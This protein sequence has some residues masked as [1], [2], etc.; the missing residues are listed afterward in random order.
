V[1]NS[2]DKGGLGNNVDPDKPYK[3]GN[4]KPPLETQFQ[5]GVSGNPGGR[6]KGRSKDLVNF[7]DILMK[8]FYKTVPA[9]LAGKV[10]NKTQGEILAMQMMKAAIS[11]TMS[12][13]RLLLQ[14]IEAHE[15]R[16]A[17]REEIKLKKQ[18]E[19]SDEIDW[20]AE[21]EEVYQ[22]LRKATA[23]I[24]QSTAPKKDE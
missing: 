24:V 20:D 23:E 14:F 22:Q 15:A 18:A 6:P 1:S 7:G 12:D 3:V 10:V 5:K 13:R 21:R 19:G 17:R 2:K 9:S 11:G 8:E 16:E 4:K